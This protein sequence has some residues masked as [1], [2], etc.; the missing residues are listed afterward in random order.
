MLLARVPT[1]AGSARLC[2]TTELFAVGLLP[3]LP[4]ADNAA[5][6]ERWL[7]AHGGGGAAGT[8]GTGR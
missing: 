7:R 2:T 3:W 4:G 6:A 8:A 1:N 5:N